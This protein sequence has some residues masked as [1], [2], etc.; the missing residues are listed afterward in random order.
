MIKYHNKHM[1][2]NVIPFVISYKNLWS[3]SLVLCLT[4][5]NYKK[6]IY[7]YR[8]LKSIS[9]WAD[10]DGWTTKW[11]LFIIVTT[12]IAAKIMIVSSDCRCEENMVVTVT[13]A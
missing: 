10:M 12:N 2:N 6:Y 9:N 5:T 8:V 13:I 4:N 1:I 7:V 3:N 11:L